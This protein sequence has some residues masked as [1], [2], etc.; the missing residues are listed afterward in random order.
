M[1]NG[2]S[3]RWASDV[4][5]RLCVIDTEWNGLCFWTL[6][7]LTKIKV[8]FVRSHFLLKMCIRS[9][10]GP[11]Y[12]IGATFAANANSSRSSVWLNLFH[13]SRPRSTMAIWLPQSRSLVR[14]YAQDIREFMRVRVRSSLLNVCIPEAAREGLLMS[15]A[16]NQTL[17]DHGLKSKCLQWL[18]E[19]TGC[20]CDSW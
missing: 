16:Y 14:F 12:F 18:Q 17:R 9:A 1:L 19:K 10:N 20:I 15:H 13:Q 2:T 7:R 11:N 6:L 8:H 3:R 4:H 5:Q